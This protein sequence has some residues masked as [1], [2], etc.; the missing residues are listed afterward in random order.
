MVAESRITAARSPADKPRTRKRR[1]SRPSLNWW[2]ER[3]EER[4]MTRTPGR[5]KFDLKASLAK[6][7]SYQPHKGK[8]KPLARK[9][10]RSA[11]VLAVATQEETKARQM[12]VIRGVRLNKRAELMMMRRKMSS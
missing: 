3:E 9:K 4:S 6:G 11:P 7:L 1:V 12:E 2:E 10:E 5:A 8:V